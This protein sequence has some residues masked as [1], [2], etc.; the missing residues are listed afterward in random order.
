MINLSEET[1]IS[2]T[3]AA[4]LLPRRRGD[5]VVHVATLYRWAQRG[6]K[7]IRLEIIQI[8]GTKCTSIEA[9]QRF[10]DRLS[11]DS[12]NPAPR[13]RT[14]RQ[15]AAAIAAAEKELIENGW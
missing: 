4:K 3:E 6:L 11:G 14:P 7:G 8:G 9:L 10:F 5:R 1:V 2:L 15:R 13:V 12:P